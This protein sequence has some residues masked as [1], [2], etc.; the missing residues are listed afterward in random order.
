[1]KG[2]PL[3]ASDSTLAQY[4]WSRQN[5]VC[6]MCDE[7]MVDGYCSDVQCETYSS[8][9]GAA[10]LSRFKTAIENTREAFNKRPSLKPKHSKIVSG[11][12]VESQRRKH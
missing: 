7:L 4:L 5:T 2:S 10:I 12:R 8:P 11:G 1:M 3:E 9:Q 6:T